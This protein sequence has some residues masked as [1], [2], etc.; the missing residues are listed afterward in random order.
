[1]AEPLLVLPP[2]TCAHCCQSEVLRLELS[3]RQSEQRRDD[4]QEQLSRQQEQLHEVDE[5][6][7]QLSLVRAGQGG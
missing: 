1:M 5:A 3:V 4:L 7:K 2:F 6:R